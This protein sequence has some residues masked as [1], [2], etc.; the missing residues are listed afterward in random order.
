MMLEISAQILVLLCAHQCISSGSLAYPQR[1]YSEPW[2][3]EVET[4]TGTAPILFNT[5]NQASLLLWIPCLE[6]A[7]IVGS[8]AHGSTGIFSGMHWVF[9]LFVCFCF[10][11]PFYFNSKWRRHSVPSHTERLQLTFLAHSQPAQE[12]HQRED[13]T[14]AYFI[15]N[16]DEWSWFST[17]R[18]QSGK[19]HWFST[20][21]SVKGR[22]GGWETKRKQ[23]PIA[24]RLQSWQSSERSNG[25]R[26]LH[27]LSPFLL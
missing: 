15:H 4:S 7:S 18:W 14:H 19:R 8:P 3:R 20:T 27:L 16:S 21:V 6:I 11:F 9:C 17:I 2:A 12:E 23:K 1:L 10:C 13:L 5:V 22:E 25:W 26:I 24:R